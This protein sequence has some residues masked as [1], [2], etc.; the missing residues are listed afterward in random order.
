[1]KLEKSVFKLLTLAVLLIFIGCAFFFKTMPEPTPQEK[2]LDLIWHISTN[3]QRK[4][5]KALDSEI[6]IMEFLADFWKSLDSTPGTP[7]NEFKDEYLKR[8]EYVEKHYPIR[9]ARGRSDKARVYLLYGPPAEIYYYPIYDT[10]LDK[11]IWITSMEIWIY[12]SPAPKMETRNLFSDIF[13]FHTK[14]VFG[15]I[16]GDGLKK[17]GLF[18][19]HRGKD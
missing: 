10:P 12:D 9:R 13:P 11:A 14:F 1:M 16:T 8:F 18:N 3:H 5:L 17:T 7:E 19:C 15:D 4:A 6:Q 2:A